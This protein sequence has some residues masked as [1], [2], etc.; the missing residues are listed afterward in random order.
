MYYYYYLT[1]TIII[2][3]LISCYVLNRCNILPH[4][5]TSSG[6]YQHI[7]GLR[8][9]AALLVVCAHSWRI[10]QVGF[11]NDEVLKANYYYN[12]N[13]GAIG[14]QIFFCITAFLFVGKILRSPETNWNIF[15]ISRIK[16]LVPLYVFFLLLLIAIGATLTSKI[17]FNFLIQTMK[18]STMGLMGNTYK[19]TGHNASDL[20]S[21]LWTLPFEIKFYIAVPALCVALS[22]KRA[23]LISLSAIV[24][25]ACLFMYLDE[26][27]A[28]VYFIIGGLTALVNEK[29]KM[30]NTIKFSLKILFIPVVIALIY[31]CTIKTQNYGVER[32][33]YMAA[34]FPVAVLSSTKLLK[35]KALSF[36]G[37][38]SYSVYLL[39]L[40]IIFIVTSTMRMF[41]KG[42]ELNEFSALLV[43]ATI[44]ACVCFVCA[45]TFKYIEYPF[46][47][48]K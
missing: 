39:H 17:D 18:V 10:N 37:E 26:F 6:R 22:T 13:L 12:V 48:K 35:S 20:T 34:F 41:L 9:I 31:S 1:P 19:L 44:C 47:R 11:I 16:R 21:I 36:M 7:D 2:S 46:L 15:F 8:G 45:F 5:Q 27:N 32:F 29:I 24:I 43:M 14:V 40:L 25:V 42:V 30:N 3:F 4:L 38:I 28:W 33:L 23:T